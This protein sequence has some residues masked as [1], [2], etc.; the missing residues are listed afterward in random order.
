MLRSRL[1]WR[2]FLSYLA[3]ALGVWFLCQPITPPSRH[4]I[5]VSFALAASAALACW[6]AWRVRG[7][8]QELTEALRRLS[9]DGAGQRVYPAGVGRRFPD[10]LGR[11]TETYNN[12]T[13]RLAR[14]LAQLEEDRQQLRTILSSMV[15]GVVALDAEQRILFANAR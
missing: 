15:E 8:V 2:L 6:Q 10:E 11:L 12:T 5:V 4:P 9:E 7:P 13:D 3:L 14:R 1:F